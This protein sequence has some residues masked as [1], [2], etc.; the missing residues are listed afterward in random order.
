M[1]PIKHITL[2]QT[3]KNISL[4]N[5]LEALNSLKAYGSCAQQV[6]QKHLESPEI[7]KGYMQ[8]HQSPNMN[9]H[10]MYHDTEQERE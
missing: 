5:Q 3:N 7:T 9:Q 2:K 8:E 6:K 1:E 10:K 4:K